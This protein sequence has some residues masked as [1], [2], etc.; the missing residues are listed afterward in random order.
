M[1][2]LSNRVFMSMGLPAVVLPDDHLSYNTTCFANERNWMKLDP[3]WFV[4]SNNVRGLSNM[5]SSNKYHFAPALII[6]LTVF[7]NAN[8]NIQIMLPT[9]TCWC[10]SIL[11][12]LRHL[13]TSQH[14]HIFSFGFLYI[15]T[16]WPSNVIWRYISGSKLTQ[17][18]AYCLMPPSHYLNQRW[19]II[20]RTQWLS[21][22]GNFAR[23][24]SA[25]SQ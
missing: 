12:F 2:D 19:L 18:M 11:S 16:Y 6:N 5:S 3:E 25:N 22:N 23:D 20:I 8:Y 21:T 15:N 24:T 7:T 4:S 10:I 13:I 9:C 17:V 1:V 14:H